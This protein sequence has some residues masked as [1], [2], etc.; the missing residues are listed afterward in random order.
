MFILGTFTLYARLAIHGDDSLQEWS[1][2][3]YY[4]VIHGCVPAWGPPRTQQL[5]DPPTVCAPPPTHRP[6]ARPLWYT[7]VVA[8][9]S[10]PPPLCRIKAIMVGR[11]FHITRYLIYNRF[12]KRYDQAAQY[13]GAMLRIVWLQIVLFVV[14]AATGPNLERYVRAPSSSYLVV[15]L[16][17][18]AHAP[19]VAAKATATEALA[20]SPLL[21]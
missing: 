4:V 11:L 21:K 7:S 16:V 2:A 12:T 20:L 8:T 18:R 1:I 15:L 6:R 17:A 14:V 9:S 5:L 3:G 10:L 19:A 13:L